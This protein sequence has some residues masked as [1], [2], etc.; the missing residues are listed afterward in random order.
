[1]V[2]LNNCKGVSLIELVITVTILAILAAGVMPLARNAE[3]RKKEIELKRN[4]RVM[5]TAI[6]DYKKTFEKMPAGPLKTGSGYPKE[7]NVLIE[8]YDFGESKKE[9]KKF[10]RRKVTDPFHP[11]ENDRDETWGWGLRSSADK[12]NSRIWGKEDVYDVYSLSEGTALDGTKY[13][14]W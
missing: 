12:P 11:P 7:L 13:N 9:K 4:L 6:D 2:T 8:G 14:E 10:L 3:L 1:M 5:R